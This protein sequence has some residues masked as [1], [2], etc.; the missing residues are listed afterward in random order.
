MGRPAF[1]QEKSLVGLFRVN[2]DGD[3][4]ARVKVRLGKSSVN[5]VEILEGLKPGDKV[6]LSD[7]SAWDAYDRVRLK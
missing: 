1:G 7:M 4:A 2:P 5:T 3:E 6:I